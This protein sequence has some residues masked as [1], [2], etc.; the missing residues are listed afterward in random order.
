VDVG[1]G[2]IVFVGIDWG[3]E[4][5]RVAVMDGAGAVLGERSITEDLAGVEAVHDLVG[6]V[7]GDVEDPEVVVG[8][9]TERGLLVRWMLAAGYEVYALNPKSVQRYRDRYRV[10]GA[11]DDVA[12]ARL[13]ADVVRTDRHRHRRLVPDSETVQVLETLARQQK[14]LVWSRRR[15]ANRLRAV[16][17]EFY[18]QALQAFGDLDLTHPDAVA[19][20]GAAPT[21][22]QAARLTQARM[23]SVLRRRGRQRGVAEAARRY[24]EALQQRH[25]EVPAAVAQAHGVV[26]AALVETI[27]AFNRGIE[28]VTEAM[29]ESLSSHPDAEIYLSQP[30]LGSLLS[31]RVLAE[32]GDVP[33]RYVDAKARKN[34]A[35][36]SPVTVASGTTKVVRRRDTRNRWLIDA[37]HQWAFTAVRV[38]PGAKAYYQQLR[39]RGHGHN[40][41][42]RQVANRLVGVLHGCLEHRQLY[43]EAKAWPHHQQPEQKAA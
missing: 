34:A 14:R 24:R 11:K 2:E 27:G 15:E 7:V 26:V 36:T 8:T 23:E 18:P 40:R 19:V 25:L 37:T 9:E 1:G 3:E 6:S 22:A 21:P 10:S 12:D 30:G 43:D 16:L 32:F 33:D 13:L 38:S 4:S 17:R 20:L 39:A 5:C 31:A 28:Q 42:L 41:A 29:D 35:G